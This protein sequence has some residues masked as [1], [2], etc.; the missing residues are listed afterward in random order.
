MVCTVSRAM[1]ITGSFIWDAY[2]YED[3]YRNQDKPLSRPMWG[4]LMQQDGIGL[5]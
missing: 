2:N 5:T 1:L 3:E 4:N